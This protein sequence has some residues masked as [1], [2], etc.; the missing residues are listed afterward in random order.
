M[1]TTL[2]HALMTVLSLLPILG[3]LVLLIVIRL[4]VA[5]SGAISLAIALAIALAFFGLNAFGIIVAVGKA[6]SLALFVSLIVW[7]ALLLYHL[8][9]G[10]KA[11]DVINKN[12]VILVEDNFIAF[13]LLAWLF[14]GV[15]QGMAGF[16]VPVVIVA[17]ILIALGFDKVKSLS[18]VL[19]GHT[20]AVTF[21][22]MGAAFF[23]IQ[24]LTGVPYEQL[25]FPMWIFNAIAILGTG[26]GV[27][28]LYDG[29]KGI[30]KG[31]AYVVPV[32]AIMV[33]VQ[34][35]TIALRLYSLASLLTAIVGLAAMLILYKLRNKTKSK[36]GL[37]SAELTLFQ[38]VLPY[39]VILVFA[40]LF[41]FLPEALRDISVSFSFPGTQTALGY[42]VRPE[43]GYA[44]IRLFGHPAVL[45]L[46]AAAVA[47]IVFRRAGGGEYSS[48]IKEALKKTVKKGVPATLALLALG[49]MSLIMM[50]SG[51]TYLLSYS[52]AE[53]TGRFYPFVAPF[54]GVLGSF[55]TGNNTNSNILFGSFQYTIAQRLEVSGAVMAA[56]QSL[57][58][59]VG[60]AIGPTLVLM[61]ALSAKLEGQESLIYRKLIVIVLIIALAMGAANFLLLRA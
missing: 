60:V 43:V 44:R 21:G 48:V 10:F 18:A 12:F 29:L 49:N 25:G 11:I 33:L 55:L 1:E 36:R 31:L 39:A 22:S 38:S 30:K 32:S 50:D 7:G 53:L 46:A 41:Q 2:P 23:I 54:F 61:G 9:D 52:I 58:G 14:T 26:F 5:K 24:M 4:S 13:A 51:M 28:W 34:Y 16:G 6:L 47:L 35:F 15:F 19:L 8:V 37:Y 42:I 57:S 59:A 27:C 17:P 45:L 40:M 56:A 20:W 3:L